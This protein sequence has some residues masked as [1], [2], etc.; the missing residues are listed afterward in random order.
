MLPCTNDPHGTHPY[1]CG[2]RRLFR[3]AVGAAWECAHASAGS[4]LAWASTVPFAWGEEAAP[5]S[6]AGA[7]SRCG[8]DVPTLWVAPAAMARDGMEP[9]DVRTR[10][11]VHDRCAWLTNTRLCTRDAQS[12]LTGRPPRV[13]RG[14]I[15]E[16]RLSPRSLPVFI[17]VSSGVVLAGRCVPPKEFR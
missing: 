12:S 11:V 14:R 16:R 13:T 8:W 6:R 2:N 7:A 10:R 3:D 9:S 15:V 4:G 5:G 1:V 17:G